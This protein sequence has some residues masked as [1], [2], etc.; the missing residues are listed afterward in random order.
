MEPIESHETD[1]AQLQDQ[2]YVLLT[3]TKNPETAELVSISRSILD[4]VRTNELVIR[5][6]VAVEGQD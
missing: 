2:L 4:R 5:R 3:T 1:F 6:L